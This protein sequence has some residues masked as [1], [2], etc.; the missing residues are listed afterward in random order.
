LAEQGLEVW[1]AAHVE[2][3]YLEHGGWD[4]RPSPAAARFN[5]W[6]L[7][8]RWGA[9][10]RASAGAADPERSVA[11]APSSRSG[12]GRPGA[13]IEILEVR[14]APVSDWVLEAELVHPRT[15]EELEAYAGTHSVSFEGWAIAGGG[16]PLKVEVRDAR[17]RLAQA[18]VSIARRDVAQRLPDTPGAQSAGFGTVV[19]TIGHP[20]EWQFEV[21]LVREDGERSALA[22]ITGRRRPLRSSFEP[23]LQPLLI[24]T[25]GR[26]GSSWLELL[27]AKHPEIVA[28]RPFIHDARLTSYW[29]AV[30]RTLAEPASYLQIIRPELY[31]GAWWT[32]EQRPGQLPLHM[33]E[34]HMAR[35]LGGESVET[36]AGFCQARIEDFYRELARA[37]GG[38]GVRYFAEKCWPEEFTPRIIAELYPE[39]REILLVRDFRDM[40]CS[41]L[42]FNAKRGTQ[43]FG[44]EATDSD[45]EFIRYLRDNANQM[46]ESWQARH[47]RSHLMRYEDLI[48]EPETTLA[49]AFAYLGV[50]NDADTIRDTIAEANAELP[51]AQRDHRTSES[52]AASIGR[53]QREL[54]AQQRAICEETF[55]DAL[56]AFGYA[57]AVISRP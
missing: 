21:E 19:G 14:R 39:G 57:S 6:L 33:A 35:W 54:S 17:G 41:I 3:T 2:L 26:T 8:R 23:R 9:Q 45:N 20:Q 36:V 31:P 43:S 13:P 16:E 12:S 10:L 32:G 5:D 49:A 29:A 1:C 55:G 11:I 50:A 42:Q 56:E 24:T 18:P 15:G 52:P 46:L 48:R 44:R 37:E 25:L 47:Q 7:D 30:L 51:A 22:T 53:W 38:D 28:C 4:A 27:L 40:V 34:T